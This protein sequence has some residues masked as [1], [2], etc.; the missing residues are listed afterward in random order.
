MDEE[1]DNQESP[2]YAND[3]TEELLEQSQSNAQATIIATIA[4]LTERK[5]SVGDWTASLGRTFGFAWDDPSP[6]E[7]G[8]FLDAMLTNFRSLGATVLTSDLGTDR[9]EATTTGFPDPE[10]CALF[11]VDPALVTAFNDVPAAL[12]RD[13]SLTWEWSR[14]G[15]ET[16][17]S[18]R[19]LATGN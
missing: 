16:H 2:G 19:Q 14:N 4:F 13:R 5:L 10:L 6:W 3:S 15:D 7:A 8:E 1:H 12:A 18:V 9:A 17:Y 11:G